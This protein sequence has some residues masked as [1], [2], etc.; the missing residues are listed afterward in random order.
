MPVNKQSQLDK[1]E[2]TL[3][4]IDNMKKKYWDITYLPNGYAKKHLT[5]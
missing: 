2:L 3:F 1:T 5:R 4:I